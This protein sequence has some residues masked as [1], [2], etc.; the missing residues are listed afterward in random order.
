MLAKDRRSTQKETKLA[1]TEV[2]I[3]EHIDEIRE[4][5]DAFGPDNVFL[6]SAYLSTVEKFPPKGLIPFYAFLRDESGNL[7]GKVYFQN[8]RFNGQD[9]LTVEK[10]G[11]CPSFF[12]ALG[13]YLKE[14][15]KNSVEFKALG[16]GNLMVSGQHAFVFREGTTKEEEHYLVDLAIQKMTDLLAASGS[17]PSV[18]LM[19]DF[20]E[21]QPFSHASAIGPKF[22]KFQV[23][24]NMLLPIRPERTSMEAYLADMTSKYR[25]RYKRARKKLDNISRRIMSYDEVVA[26]KE[27][28]L[29]SNKFP[30]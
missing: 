15:V 5:W 16:V 25:T 20:Y 8:K 3:F 23:Q 11:R 1:G 26:N 21:E 9:S 7:I 29:L 6:K 17:Q 18:I 14:M 24:P 28:M 4:K 27:L 13:F 19:K 30:I 2:E 12:S 10:E 22:Y